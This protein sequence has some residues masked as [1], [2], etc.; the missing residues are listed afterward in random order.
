MVVLQPR[1]LVAD[2]DEHLLPLMDY[3]QVGGK[4]SF[5]GISSLSPCLHL[6]WG[7]R[8]TACCC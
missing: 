6:F 4:E 3:L 8:A 2:V 5:V 1:C 7:R